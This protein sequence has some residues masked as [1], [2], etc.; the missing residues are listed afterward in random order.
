MP[1]RA[2]FA[3]V[4]VL[5]GGCAVEG[6]ENVF[7]TPLEND[8]GGSGDGGNSA[9]GSTSQNPTVTTSNPETTTDATTQTTVTTDVT[10]TTTTDMA[11]TTGPMPDG[12]TVFC[13]GLPC[14]AGSVCCYHASDASQDHCAPECAAT[15]EWSTIACN[16]PDDCP[17][18]ECCGNYDNQQGWGDVMCAP[19]CSTFQV[20]LCFEDPSACDSGAQACLPSQ[21]LGVGYS[22][23][24][25]G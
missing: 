4:V 3:T 8:G 7:G 24:S 19:Q 17:G 14:E 16:G 10:A 9:G 5:L 15:D 23:C 20:E 13:A 11:T 21:G 18:Q 22:Y 2:C 12:P 6:V 25:G 1:L